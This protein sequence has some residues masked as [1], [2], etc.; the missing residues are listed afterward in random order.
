MS[1]LEILVWLSLAVAAGFIRAGFWFW[2]KEGRKL[3]KSGY[4]PPPPGFFGRLGYRL[5]TRLAC[6]LFVGPVRVIGRQNTNFSGK[7]II[8]PNHV[9]EFDFAVASQALPFAFRQLA[10]ASE[11]VGL[12]ATIAAWLGFCAVQGERGKAKSK[13][14]ADAVIET[15][16]NI[17]RKNRAFMMFPQGLLCRD[18]VLR[19]EQFRTGWIRI[20]NRASDTV[21][22]EEL[23][24]LPIGIVYQGDPIM[25]TRFHRLVNWLRFPNFLLRKIGLAGFR[26]WRAVDK[27]KDGNPVQV[28]VRNYGAT[29]VVGK[30]I[31]L[32]SLP[33]DVHEATE[34]LRKAIQ[35]EVDRAKCTADT[36]CLQRFLEAQY[37]TRSNFWS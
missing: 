5:L 17:L 3:Q 13:A 26:V 14:N 31:P 20:L 24:A 25:A 7:L 11:V 34:V 16:A 28:V 27:D 37:S 10:V 4:L 23:A 33:A 19:P 21:G 8:V 12:R 15:G 30:P 18:N 36:E 2:H 32:S 1:I 22:K 35:K 9:L 6:F 29:V